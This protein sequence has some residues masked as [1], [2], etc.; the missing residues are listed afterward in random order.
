MTTTT[1]KTI[2]QLQTW[3][4]AKAKAKQQAK[5]LRDLMANDKTIQE[6]KEAAKF[7]REAVNAEVSQFKGKHEAAYAELEVLTDQA[8]EQ[9]SLFDDLY[10]S[11]AVRG[12]S[13]TAEELGAEVSMTTKV[14]L[15]KKAEQKDEPTDTEL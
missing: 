11:C 15:V 1:Q 6:L 7:A 9:K 5:V 13:L 10:L 2:T 4:D 14:K 8:A 12:E 3:Q